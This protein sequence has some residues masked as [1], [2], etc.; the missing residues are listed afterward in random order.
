MSR[1]TKLLAQPKT[2]NI[3]GEDFEIKPLTTKNLELFI[4]LTSNDTKIKSEAMQKLIVETIKLSEPEATQEE[5]DNLP[6]DIV[7]EFISAIMEVN[8]QR[9]DSE[10]LKAIEALKKN[11]ESK[12]T[13]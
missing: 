6:V 9:T 7:S 2:F 13:A 11:A 8:G 10:K 3:G 12:S 5:I 1:L 4:K